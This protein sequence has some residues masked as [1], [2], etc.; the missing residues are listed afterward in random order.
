MISIKDHYDPIRSFDRN[1]IR[2]S[3]IAL[4][5][6]RKKKRWIHNRTEI[7][8]YLRKYKTPRKESYSPL[9][10]IRPQFNKSSPRASLLFQ[11]NTILN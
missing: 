3:N 8:H 9:T 4:S 10:Q 5:D 6:E 1:P 7:I 2:R 11:I